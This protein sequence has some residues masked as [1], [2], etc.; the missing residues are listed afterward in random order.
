M[1]EDLPVK[2]TD[3]FIADIETMDLSPLKDKMF[4][5]AVSTGDRSKP[6]FLS[7]TV[8]GPYD[9]TEMCDEVGIMWEH[10][11]HHAKVIMTQKDRN[12][13]IKILDENTVDYIEAHYQDI[14]TDAMLEGIFD[15]KIYTCRAGIVEADLSEEPAKK[16]DSVEEVEEE[17]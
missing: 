8:R 13:P 6:K 2:S 17:L 12:Q 4:L 7:T 11:Q 9:F 16:Q 15:E 5:I 10:Q 1:S 3:E 14:I